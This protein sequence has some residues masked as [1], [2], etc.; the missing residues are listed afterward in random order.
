MIA[1]GCAFANC[2]LGGA[3]GHDG[4]LRALPF[5]RAGLRAPAGQPGGVRRSRR[6]ALA[7]GL[8]RRLWLPISPWALFLTTGLGLF[9]L[10]QSGRPL[11]WMR[12]PGAAVMWVVIGLYCAFRLGLIYQAAERKKTELRRDKLREKQLQDGTGCRRR[13]PW[14]RAVSRP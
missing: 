10:S 12:L 9:A 11:S 14:G 2:L 13:P 4:L 5:G 6:G 7:L 3:D 8:Q 1:L